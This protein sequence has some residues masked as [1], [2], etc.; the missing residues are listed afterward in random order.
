MTGSFVHL[1]VH[2]EYSVLDG[3][4]RVPELV[5][6]CVRLGMPAVAVT[7]HGGLHGAQVLYRA[8]VDAGIKPVVGMEAFAAPRV[9]VASGRGGAHLTMWARDVGGL[10]NLMVLSTLGFAEGRVGRW[11]RVDV[12][13]VAAHSGG[14]MGTTGCAAGEVS[15]LLRV[16]RER[17]A[18]E[19]AALWRDVFGASEFFVELVDHGVAGERVVRDRLLRVA[20]KLKAPLLV[21]NDVHHL[22]ASD[23][24]VQDALLSV[25]SGKTVRDPSRFRLGGSGHHLRSAEEM[26]ALDSSDA[27]QEGCRATLAVAERVD[28]AGMFERGGAGPDVVEDV[29][30]WAAAHGVLVGAGLEVDERRRGEVLRHLGERWGW[31]RVAQV[32]AFAR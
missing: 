15:A 32:G 9:P 25:G 11:P 30:A 17:E 4:V 19:V 2:T 14:V 21:T 31:D 13:V 6:E 18:L 27:W 10:R 1:H 22:R 7:D 12:E 29:V 23:A 26:Y 8:A 28:P 5:A 3:A 24:A 20:E 16:G